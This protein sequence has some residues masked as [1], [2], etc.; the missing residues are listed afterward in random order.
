MSVKHSTLA[1]REQARQ[2]R[3][4]LREARR[5]TPSMQVVSMFLATDR[6][7]AD[8]WIDIHPF[9]PYVI[10]ADGWWRPPGDPRWHPPQ[11]PNVRARFRNEVTS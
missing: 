3:M 5:Q 2:A 6:D 4:I 10:S 11:E 7:G 8:L 1:T 9:G